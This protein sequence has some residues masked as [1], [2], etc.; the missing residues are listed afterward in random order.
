MNLPMLI[1][2]TF[3][4]ESGMGDYLIMTEEGLIREICKDAFIRKH[5]DKNVMD[6]INMNGGGFRSILICFFNFMRD[7]MIHIQRAEGN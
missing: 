1:L 4:L 2:T 3:H 6:S 7:S 5:I